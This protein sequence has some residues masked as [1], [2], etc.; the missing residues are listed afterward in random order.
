MSRTPSTLM[1]LPMGV[2]AAAYW[3][4]TGSQAT[5]SKTAMVA[6]LA[7]EVDNGRITLADVRRLGQSQATGAQLNAV[8]QGMVQPA[9][10]DPV[11]PMRVAASIGRL[12]SLEKSIGQTMTD[13]QSLDVRMGNV[14]QEVAA[15]GA[16]L[17]SLSQTTQDMGAAVLGLS[18][19]LDASAVSAHAETKSLRA[20]VQTLAENIG[21]IRIDPATV[22]AAV[23]G[24]VADAFRPFAA[25]VT[26]AGA[27]AQVGAMVAARVVGRQ[28]CLDV[29]GVDLRDRKGNPVEVDLWDHPEAP[30]VDPVYIW[31]EDLLAALLLGQDGAKVWLGGPK[32]TGKTEAARQFAAR[33]GRAFIRFNF[34]KF[35]TS[36]DYIGATGLQSGSTSFVPGPVLAGLTTPG[37]V[38][39]LDE[40][41]NI[42]PGEAA[43]LNG[44]LEPSGSV[45]IGGSSW[46]VLP[47]VLVVAADNTLG[48]GDDSGR[49][50]G[51]RV[52]N[53]A[54]VDRFSLVM[55]MDYLPR[56]M[57]VQ[58]LVSHT[59][60][61]PRLAE[62]VIDAVRLCRE[63]VST[64][65]L[66][67]AP[68]IRS[69]IGFV[70]ALRLMP[71]AKAWAAAVSN[72]QPVEGAAGLE[73][74]FT[75]AIDQGFIDS[76]A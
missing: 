54:L 42:D 24:A 67:D 70:R 2:I 19:R 45:S 55:R 41:T 58:A 63:K 72:R 12:Q 31:S 69:C 65:D 57:E 5:N 33:T 34:R 32:G 8:S 6:A 14:G 75:S 46:S 18:Q 40:L 74:A 9:P 16:S 49:Y 60:C 71:V 26:A 64:G 7:Q 44:L 66:V 59:R 35:T 73:A 30:A 51:T 23:T 53:S 56:D 29:F 50:A 3:A 27:Q 37:A 52:M 68:S 20:Q 15:Q 11:L 47:G 22:Q 13:V 1:G 17:R 10:A 62:H 39:L 36:E 21:Q 38:V 25:A 48:N 76:I 61:D 28:T 4:V 43:P